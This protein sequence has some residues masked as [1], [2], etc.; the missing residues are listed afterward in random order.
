MGKLLREHGFVVL[1]KKGIFFSVPI[2]AP[3]V[4]LFC[5]KKK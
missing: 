2:L 3:Y 4:M 5:E 1:H